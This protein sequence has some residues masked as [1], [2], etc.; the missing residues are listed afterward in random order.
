MNADNYEYRHS[1]R[2]T[3]AE[4]VA[5]TAESPLYEKYVF[6]DESGRILYLS[7]YGKSLYD[8][9]DF[10]ISTDTV[11]IAGIHEVDCHGNDLIVWGRRTSAICK[12]DMVARVSMPNGVFHHVKT[13]WYE[14]TE[15]G[16]PMRLIRY[17]GDWVKDNLDI[18]MRDY[19]ETTYD[20]VCLFGN[21]YS[22]YD[23]LEALDPDTLDDLL[24][25]EAEERASEGERNPDDFISYNDLEGVLAY[26]NAEDR[27][28]Y[29]G[30]GYTEVM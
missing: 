17:I 19:V 3:M 23:I 22:P 27:V 15:D 7:Y 20:S 26:W 2:M 28:L 29:L 14:L 12:G 18:D 4:A 10:G 25:E 1:E 30:H 8:I 9:D 24:T 16:Q 13:G 5:L 6:F 11:D 21:Y